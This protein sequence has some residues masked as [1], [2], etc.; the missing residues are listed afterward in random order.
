MTDP[1]TQSMLRGQTK[2]Q[3]RLHPAAPMWAGDVPSPMVP[4]PRTGFAGLIG[5]LL[6]KGTRAPRVTI[7]RQ[8]LTPGE[9]ALLRVVQPGPLELKD[10]VVLLICEE[11]TDD[12]TTSR[13]RYLQF[14]LTTG[15]IRIPFG[16]PL[17]RVLSMDIP[18]TARPSSATPGSEVDWK[19]VLR[20]ELPD[21]HRI[22]HEFA[23]DVGP[24]PGWSALGPA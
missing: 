21:K 13:R 9:K 24:L 4:Q 14:L 22:Q 18:A 6:S 20:G 7:E 16:N 17:D 10:Y 15:P 8:P 23:L 11:A 1:A 2:P 3:I 12:G 19:L 5:G